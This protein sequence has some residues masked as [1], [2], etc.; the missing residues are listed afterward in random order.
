M[1]DSRRRVP[2]LPVLPAVVAI[3]LFVLPLLALVASVSWDRLFTL[4]GSGGSRDALRLS[5]VCSVTATALSIALGIPLAWLLARSEFPGRGLLRAFL[6]LPMVLPP[7]VGGTAL[8]L[9]FA[10]DGFAGHLLATWFGLTLPGSTAGV[11][12]AETFVA[13]PFLILATEGALRATDSRYE[14]V[15]ATLGAGR[16]TTFRRV[17]LPLIFP[18]VMAGIVLC[19]ARA[20]GEFGATMTFAGNV[21]GQT[22]TMPVA[23]S[24]TLQ[25]DR[26]GAIALSFVL[27]VVCVGVLFALR[28]R[29]VAPV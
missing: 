25:S 6:L 5:L 10:P 20:L 29:W 22:R 4:L 18:S 7:V 9:A 3:A 27:I 12:L 23:I 24:T 14:A 28:E 19:W 15:A 21:A 2:M 1:N 13:M 8:A 26:D 11:V 16:W 17:T